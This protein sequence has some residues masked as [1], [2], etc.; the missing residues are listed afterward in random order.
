MNNPSSFKKLRTL[1]RVFWRLRK[2]DTP[3]VRCKPIKLIQT[4]E[5]DYYGT[6]KIWLLEYF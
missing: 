2:Y 1:E 6:K 5:T 4:F 3:D